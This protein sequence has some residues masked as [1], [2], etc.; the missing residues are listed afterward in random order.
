MK[1]CTLCKRSIR[2]K[3]SGGNVIYKCYCGKVE[4]TLPED[5]M[6]GNLTLLS[7]EKT[8][9]MYDNLITLAP[10]DRTN[11]LDPKQCPNCGLDY[12]TRLRIG[13]SETTIYRCKCGYTKQIK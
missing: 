8:T 5:V 12:M 4:P 13:T 10:F 3:I 6:I 9:E 7:T 1:F 2:R 11:Q